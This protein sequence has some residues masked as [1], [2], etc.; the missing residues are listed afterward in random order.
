M[1]LTHLENKDMDDV[2]TFAMISDKETEGQKDKRIQL[3]IH[4]LYNKNDS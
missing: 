3:K 1:P 4:F 2:L